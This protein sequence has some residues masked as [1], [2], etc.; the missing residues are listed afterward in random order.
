MWT[1]GKYAFL[2][3]MVALFFVADALDPKGW[4]RGVAGCRPYDA[5]IEVAWRQDQ[6]E[7]FLLM[8]DERFREA[9]DKHRSALRLVEEQY[10]P[11]HEQV[12]N[13]I[14]AV[15]VACLMQGK[16]PEA[17]VL[18]LRALRLSEEMYENDDPNLC[19]PLLG[20]HQIAY[21]RGHYAIAADYAKQ[22]LEIAEAAFGESDQRLVDYLFDLSD[23]YEQQNL[24]DKAIP[25]CERMVELLRQRPDGSG[26]SLGFTLCRLAFF[27]QALGKYS[28][29]EPLFLQSLE[30]LGR[31]DAG[32]EE[33]AELNATV[34][35]YSELLRA[36]NRPAEA[37]ALEERYRRN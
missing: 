29:A 8:D 28:D 27:Y 12:I 30:I 34:C 35:N 7:A 20:L 36:T 5:L 1:K 14:N 10:G 16:L 9:E 2:A 37:K 31:V 33:K 18:Y 4:I 32:E 19:L 22:K 13:A 6:H 3:C 15:G 26:R 23:S 11:E 17:E 21:E 24:F 25:L